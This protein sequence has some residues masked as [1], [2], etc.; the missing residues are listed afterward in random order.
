MVKTNSNPSNT[1]IKH[2]SLS[3]YLVSSILPTSLQPVQS[4]HSACCTILPVHSKYMN[5][6]QLSNFAI[7][8][9]DHLETDMHS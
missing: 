5:H 2:L 4:S 9:L 3:A 7:H 6:H 1:H 8:G